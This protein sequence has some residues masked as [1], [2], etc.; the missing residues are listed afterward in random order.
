MPCRHAG[1]ALRVRHVPIYVTRVVSC[2]QSDG[3]FVRRCLEHFF[4]S[5]PPCRKNKQ[6]P[7]SP[8]IAAS[9]SSSSTH[10]T[11]G[12]SHP[13]PDRGERRSCTRVCGWWTRQ[14]RVR[15]SGEGEEEDGVAKE[16]EERQHNTMWWKRSGGMTM[17]L[18]EASGGTSARASRKQRH[19][20]E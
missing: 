14:R 6:N 12:S 8:P 9:G 11:F 15:R 20:C 2:R 17:R 4:L 16:G 7:Q 19:E 3:P 18:R 5:S 13:S 10:P 1:P